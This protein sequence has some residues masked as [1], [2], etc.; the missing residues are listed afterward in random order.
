M[1][2]MKNLY[3]AVQ[4]M[5]REGRTVNAVAKAF[6]LPVSLVREMQEDMEEFADKFEGNLPK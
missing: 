5:L 6:D 3:S 2:A 1:S 4:E